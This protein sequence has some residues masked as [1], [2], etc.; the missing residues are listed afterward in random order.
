MKKYLQ[1][2]QT[3]LPEHLVLSQ[4]S[5][6]VGPISL[7]KV[8]CFFIFI[9]FFGF[10]RQVFFVNSPG[11]AG[12]HFADEAVLEA[13][14]LHLPLTPQVLGLKLCATNNQLRWAAS[15]K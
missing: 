15:N 7:L 1:S 6:L 12:T 5:N 8:D 14:E 10:S 2:I 4:R 9:L 13:T 11:C 3:S